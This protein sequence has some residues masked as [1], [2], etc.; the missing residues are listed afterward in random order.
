MKTVSYPLRVRRGQAALVLALRWAVLVAAMLVFVAL[1]GGVVAGALSW[2]DAPLTA[3]VQGARGPS[4]TAL[5]RFVTQLGHGTVLAPV[6]VLAV[7]AVRWAGYLKPALYLAVTA[8]GAGLLNLVLKLVFAR[9][10]PEA[11]S[12]LAGAS[13]YSFPSGH[14]M[15]SAAIYGAIAIVFVYRFPRWSIA[16]VVVC[17]AL[18]AAIGASRVYLGVHYPSDVIG[19]WAL[20]L[21]W[22]LWL[23]PA[24][25]AKSSLPPRS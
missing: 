11:A 16:G 20:G 8:G 1:A 2:L 17:C 7:V 14:S 24:L 22:A 13:G 3:L 23:R 4:L 25:V 5:M 18:V 21:A 12:A 19:G 15:A 6:A 9:P 10:R